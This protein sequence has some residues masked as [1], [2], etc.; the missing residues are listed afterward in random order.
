MLALLAAAACL[1]PTH[2]TSAPAIDGLLDDPVW[3]TVR[4]S[5][6][7]T[8]SFPHDGD[9]PGEHTTVRVAYDDDNLYV[10]IDCAQT[11]PPVVRLTR[12][13]R[14]TDGDRVSIDLDTSHDRR[15]AFHFQVSSA[16][17][18]VD[19]LR[20]DDTELST[21]WDDV[22]QAEVA[23]R[24]HGWSAELK[25]PLR[26]LRLHD[27]VA[28]WGFQVRRWVGAT[29]EEDVWAY[30]PR[31]SGG[32]VSRYGELGPFDGVAPRGNLALVPF[33]LTRYVTT[34]TGSDGSAVPSPYG[35]GT[36]AAAG[37]DVTWR[38][39]PPITLQGALY[40][41]FGQVEADQIVINLTTT[42][43]EYPEKRPFFLQGID[44]FQT[45]IQLLYTR[46]IGRATDAPVLPDGT[47]MLGA[48]GPA[49]VLGAAKLIASAGPVD[50]GALS[51]VTGGVDAAT[52]QGTSVLAAP[53]ASHHVVRV[54][55]HGDGFTF[56]A[57]ATAQQQGDDPLRHPVVNGMALCPEGSLVAPGARCSHDSVTGGLDGAWRSSDGSWTANGQLAGTRMQGGPTRMLLDGTQLA[58]GDTGLGGTFRVA[59]E[60]GTL[61]GELSYEG[62]S[63]KF[64]I[65]DLGYLDRQNVQHV[66]ASVGAYS[67]HPYG[68]LV[69]EHTN[70]EIF[71]RR[72]NDG[73]VLP[74][75]YQWNLGGTTR[76]LWGV[77]A[78]L[79]WRPH[80]FDDRELGDG[81]ALERSGRLGLE[82]EVTS[83][84]RR[85][86]VA[87]WGQ[88]LRSTAG[89]W[90]LYASGGVKL[91]PR[92]NLELELDPDLVISRGEPR[93]VDGTD[94]IGPR[95]SRLYATSVGVTTRV[96]W[97]LQRDLTLQAYVQGL[98]ASLEHRGAYVADPSLRV[99]AL[100]QLQP[101]SFD[102]AMYDVREGV[103]DATVVARWEYRPGSVAYLVYSH[104]AQPADYALMEARG[105]EPAALVRGPSSDAL[106][107]KLSWA[108]LK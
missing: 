50:V 102:P 23:H 93:F 58:S 71:Y 81:R 74:S 46:R 40:P 7:F 47:T 62:Y 1:T 31:D 55:A 18:L 51:A 17:T 83:D 98:I 91:R 69:D 101:A 72:N 10:A 12:R 5:D 76:S 92:D 84:P 2:V 35:E 89:G 37:L 16:G 52:D 80:Y 73:L 45:P 64:E 49:P 44:L 88:Q 99:I 96:T 13:D 33:V 70:L 90:E 66:F 41:D 11:A 26:I 53:S 85:E 61:R 34:H 87:W 82:L 4:A 104:A 54:R 67:P 75:G 25:I 29:G 77:W 59:R 107:V 106:L 39:A 48:V 56:G 95:F 6:R 36:S 97:T 65:D 30:S 8:Q 28:T 9:K 60:G 38:P 103:L 42:E 63:R 78:E 57:L 27:G 14:E 108:W 79:H 86:L 43:T 3:Q 20:Y 32:E 15:S 22:W 21:D 24:E 105:L 68:P 19:G 94:P 100:D